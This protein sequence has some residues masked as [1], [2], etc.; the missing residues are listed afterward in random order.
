MSRQF[1][2]IMIL[3]IIAA[4]VIAAARFVLVSGAQAGAAANTAGVAQ[5]AAAAAGEAVPVVALGTA[6]VETG[7]IFAAGAL[8]ETDVDGKAVVKA[9]GPG[10]A[11][12]LE[13]SG[14]A[15][16]FVEV[17]LIPN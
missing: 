16:E 12:A 8:L 14:A 6:V 3:T 2:P 15:G 13:A 1:Q 4:G 17:I 9:A 11:R 7:G 5:Y 10:V